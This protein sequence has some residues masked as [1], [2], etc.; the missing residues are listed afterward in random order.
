LIAKTRENRDVTVA[1]IDAADRRLAAVWEWPRALG[2]SGPEVGVAA[3]TFE[4]NVLSRLLNL[5]PPPAFVA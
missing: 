4:P 3:A 1:R 5:S 2:V